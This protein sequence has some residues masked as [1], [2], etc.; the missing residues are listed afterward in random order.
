MRITSI[1][2]KGGLEMAS[3]F[4]TRENIC[5]YIDN[6]LDADERR[7]FEEHIRDCR[8]C[9]RE[10]EEMKRIAGSATNFRS[11]SCRPGSKRNCMKSFLRLQAAGIN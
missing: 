11:L 6:V 7:S 9:R 5:A 4:D 3:C 2:V 10:L 1:N 8:D